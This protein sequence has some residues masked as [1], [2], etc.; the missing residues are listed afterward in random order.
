[1]IAKFIKID[2]KNNLRTKIYEVD[3]VLSEIVM[4]PSSCTCEACSQIDKNEKYYI[5]TTEDPDEIVIPIKTVTCYKIKETESMP[6][7]QDWAVL[8]VLAAE[9]LGPKDVCYLMNDQGKTIETI[10]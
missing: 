1:M 7:K 3:E 4:H 2:E 5:H 6:D 9:V 10:R 8:T